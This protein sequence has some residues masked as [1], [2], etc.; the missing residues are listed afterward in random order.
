MEVN[1]KKSFRRIGKEDQKKFNNL[2]FK[3]STFA[4]IMF[5]G[6]LIAAIVIFP[7]ATIAFKIVEIYWYY[8]PKAMFMFLAVCFAL[9]MLGNALSNMVT[10]KAAK[11]IDPDMDNLQEIDEYAIFYFQL[12]NIGFG[13]F[14]GT[15]LII[16]GVSAL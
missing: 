5:F 10:V 9:F 13:L 8:F 12:T 7:M 2:K 15:L 6:L 4:K 11:L 14:I 3:K 1:V 16:F